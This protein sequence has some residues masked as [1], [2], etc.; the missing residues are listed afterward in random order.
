MLKVKGHDGI[1]RDENT[2]AILSVNSVEYTKYINKRDRL[3]QEKLEI[4]ALKQDV[5]DIKN[6]LASILNS[7]NKE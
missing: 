2:K 3:R 5:T 7:L 6:M 1:V 4:E